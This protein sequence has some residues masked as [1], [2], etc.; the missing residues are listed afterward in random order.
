MREIETAID[1]LKHE[2]VLPPLLYQ[3]FKQERK[4][5]QDLHL[6]YLKHGATH[7]EEESTI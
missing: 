2:H 6:Y 4:F 5:I 3:Q 1:Q 7:N